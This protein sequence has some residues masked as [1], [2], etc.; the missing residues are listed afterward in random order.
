MLDYFQAAVLQFTGDTQPLKNMPALWKHSRKLMKAASAWLPQPASGIYIPIQVR[1]NNKLLHIVID[2][3]GQTT[4]RSLQVAYQ[5]RWVLNSTLKPWIR[6][7]L[8][9]TESY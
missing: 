2:P 5:I 8:S 7:Q 1:G 9:L 6:K 4:E 3:I